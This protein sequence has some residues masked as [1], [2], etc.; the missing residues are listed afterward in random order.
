VPFSNACATDEAG[1]ESASRSRLLLCILTVALATGSSAAAAQEEDPRQGVN[2]TAALAEL[3][4]GALVG[5]GAHEGGHLLFNVIFDAS[6]SIT[7]VEFHRI[8]FFAITHAPNLPPRQEYAI[9]AAGFWVQHA[10]NEWI[11]TTRPRLRQ[12]RAAFTKG[13]LAFNIGA[14]VAYSFAAFARTG[15]DERDTRGMAVSARMDEPWIGALILAPAALD[16]WRYLD[17]EARWAVWV[18]RAAKVAVML[19]V[20]R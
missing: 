16:A 14:S 9:S 15:P 2:Q 13:L 19:L 6:P 20:L 11:L 3:I 4:G 1:R 5:L 10:T 7:R 17:P 12:D 18:S 8:P